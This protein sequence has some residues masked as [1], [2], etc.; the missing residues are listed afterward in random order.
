MKAKVIGQAGYTFD[1][2]VI[3]K[4]FD[5][6]EDF[7]H[8]VCLNIKNTSND[9]LWNFSKGNVE[10]LEDTKLEVGGKVFL[11]P[12][13]KW[14]G[15]GTKDSANPLG[16]VGVI[17]SYNNSDLLRGALGIDVKWG[18]GL[19]NSYR[20]VDLIP[21]AKKEG[22]IKV[23]PHT[24]LKQKPKQQ[25]QT[26]VYIAYRDG[27]NHLTKRVLSVVVRA[28][29]KVITIT[30][31]RNIGGLIIRENVTIPSTSVD[32]IDITSKEAN[33][34]YFFDE[35][36]QVKASCQWFDKNHKFKTRSH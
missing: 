2:E 21:V 17:T 22:Q 15:S 9:G 31:E 27:S 12:T 8:G 7:G 24:K 5:I 28:E 32:W 18:N 14:V 10:L 25:T 23:S 3:G 19:A 34:S 26:K 4:I 20:E 6:V 36:G 11:N 13:S 1:K 29:D 35:H 16:V 30:S 33:Y